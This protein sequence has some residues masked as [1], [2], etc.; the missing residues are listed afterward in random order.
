MFLPFKCPCCGK[1]YWLE[2]SI[3]YEEKVYLASIE[4]LREYVLK[5]MNILKVWDDEELYFEVLDRFSNL[6]KKGEKP[7]R[8]IKIISEIYGIPVLMLEEALSEQLTLL[9][10]KPGGRI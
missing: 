2:V 10:A 8:A 7:D 3:N 1:N 9:K 6:V 4:E 5:E